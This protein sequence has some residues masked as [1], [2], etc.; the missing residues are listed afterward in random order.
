[1]GGHGGLNILPQKRWNV[2]NFDNREKV[3][4]DKKKHEEQREKEETRRNEDQASARYDLLRAQK[5]R[6]QEAEKERTKSTLSKIF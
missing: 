3:E 4:K 2:Y 5:H 6:E 1:M